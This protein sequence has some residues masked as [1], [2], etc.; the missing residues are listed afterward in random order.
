MRYFLLFLLLV[1][2]CDA[3]CQDKCRLNVDCPPSQ[4]CSSIHGCKKCAPLNAKRCGK[5]SDCGAGERCVDGP[6][7]PTLAGQGLCERK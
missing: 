5:N 3:G 7:R 6:E 1:A 2:I 4:F